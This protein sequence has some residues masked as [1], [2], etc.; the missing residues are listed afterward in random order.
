MSDNLPQAGPPVDPH[1]ADALRA[2]YPW[3]GDADR[4][5]DGDTG[6]DVIEVPGMHPHAIEADIGVAVIRCGDREHLRRML[7][8]EHARALERRDAAARIR[9][10]LRPH[11]DPDALPTGS[12]LAP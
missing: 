7:K 4:L 3:T 5:V 1:V 12:E 11:R 10:T 6:W 2:L 8:A 9:T